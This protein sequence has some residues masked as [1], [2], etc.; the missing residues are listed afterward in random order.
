MGLPMNKII[1]SECEVLFVC[2]SAAEQVIISKL[3]NARVIDILPE[4]IID[5]TRT[6]SAKAIEEKYLQVDYDLPVYIV[7]ILDSLKENFKLGNLYSGR[8]TV[9]NIHTRPEIEMLIIHHEGQYEEFKKSGKKPSDYCKENL[10][11]KDVKSAAFL[12]GYWDAKS[13]VAASLAYQ[14]K[15]KFA[16]GELCLCDL[17]D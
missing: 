3:C 17:W 1:P 12:S 13:L 9:I 4:H 10:G 5:I 7:R 16:K 8:F 11:M 6:R 15:H 2:E 14:Q